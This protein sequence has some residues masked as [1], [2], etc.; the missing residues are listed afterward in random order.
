MPSSC[1]PSPQCDHEGFL[2]VDMRG[3]FDLRPDV[4]GGNISLA[5]LAS[6]SRLVTC[7]APVMF[8]EGSLES[9]FFPTAIA[10]EAGGGWGCED[11]I[12][13]H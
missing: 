8:G 12:L 3:F 5:V 9:I 1:N 4:R 11:R 7:C 10:G 2:L 6:T 13:A